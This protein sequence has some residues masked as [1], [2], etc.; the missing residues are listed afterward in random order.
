MHQQVNKIMNIFQCMSE[1]NNEHIVLSNDLGS[2]LVS[3]KEIL[4]LKMTL[5]MC[6]DLFRCTL[7]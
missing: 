3:F 4:D 2:I 7:I 1:E 6:S 5:Q